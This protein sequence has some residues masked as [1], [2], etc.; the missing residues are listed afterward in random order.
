GLR[1]RHD[2]GRVGRHVSR[3]RRIA[4]VRGKRIDGRGEPNEP[5]AAGGSAVTLTGVLMALIA[6]EPGKEIFTTP[7]V[8]TRGGRLRVCRN[9]GKTQPASEQDRKGST[10]D[11]PLEP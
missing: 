7:G 2:L 6:A 10:H 8:P 3:T 4:D 9:D 1:I 5:R 11:F